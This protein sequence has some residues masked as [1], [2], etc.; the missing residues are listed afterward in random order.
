MAIETITDEFGDIIGADVDSAIYRR[1]VPEDLLAAGTLLGLDDFH[2]GAATAGTTMAV[3]TR[4]FKEVVR[5]LSE[6]VSPF[7][8]VWRLHAKPMPAWAFNSIPP[9]L[10]CFYIRTQALHDHYSESTA[11]ELK[12]LYAVK[13]SLVVKAVLFDFVD[14]E[15]GI[16]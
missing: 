10:A 9:R 2:N 12:R 15:V 7:D 16:I 13:G 4:V 8:Q 5:N 1:D 3:G 6:P 11:E 14:E